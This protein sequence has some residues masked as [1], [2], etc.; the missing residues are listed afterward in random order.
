[1]G[2]FKASFEKSNK[3]LVGNFDIAPGHRY[4]GRGFDYDLVIKQ[5]WDKRHAGAGVT[6]RSR[7]D[8]TV[9]LIPLIAWLLASR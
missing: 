1:M 8:L 4:T 9:Q 6:T 3:R 2:T 5:S 7:Q